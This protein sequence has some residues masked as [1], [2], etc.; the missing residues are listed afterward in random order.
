VVFD[1]GGRRLVVPDSAELPLCV[2]LSPADG[3][4]FD[5][6]DLGRLEV[7]VQGFSEVSLLGLAN[8]DE[9][10][11]ESL[12]EGKIPPAQDGQRLLLDITGGQS[13]SGQ[14]AWRTCHTRLA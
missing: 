8:G 1:A 10:E 4:L 12:A 7:T 2:F 13:S 3:E 11:W 5:I 9:S 6:A 14:L